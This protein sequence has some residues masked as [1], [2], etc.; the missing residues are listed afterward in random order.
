LAVDRGPSAAGAPSHGTTGTMVASHEL[1]QSVAGRRD[2]NKE[3][4]KTFDITK[5]I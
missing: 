2:G 1:G 3:R 4:Q 5:W